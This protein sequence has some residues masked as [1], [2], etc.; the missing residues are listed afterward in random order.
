M[1]LGP[2]AFFIVSAYSA[3]ALIVAVLVAWVAFDYRRQTRA[4]A[5]QE[6]RG[7]TRRSDRT[8]EVTP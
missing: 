1:T 7:V 2:H 5:E 6:A 3:A 8:G 4:L